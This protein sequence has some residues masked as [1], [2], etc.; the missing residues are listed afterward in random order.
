MLDATVAGYLRLL[1][2]D[3]PPA[4]SVD[5]LAEIHRAHVERVAYN[6]VNIALGRPGPIEPVL[7]AEALV[8]TGRVGYCFQLNGALSALLLALGFEVRRHRGTVW[9][10]PESVSMHPF[11]N[12]LALTAHGLPSADNPGGAWLVDA[13]LGDALHEPLPLVAGTYE[14]GPFRYGLEAS[15]VLPGGW[16]LRH[17]PA[18]SFAGMD[19]EESLADPDAF[20]GAHLNLSTA[21]DSP[22]VRHLTAQRRDGCG[23]DRLL[24][25]KIQ[26]IEGARVVEWELSRPAEWF[27]ALA[28]VFGLTLDDVNADERDLLWT[29]AQANQANQSDHAV[30]AVQE[31]PHVGR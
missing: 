7:V 31:D 26:R 10:R 29:R 16:R 30:H 1:G 27:A 19:F 18:G 3:D 14:Q 17:D 13:G 12:H 2:F 20:A 15:P 9:K 5:A 24:N 22:F 6:T 4:P 11:A 21:A 28:D 8:A 25:G 23:V